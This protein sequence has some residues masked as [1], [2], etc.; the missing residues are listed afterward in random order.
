MKMYRLLLLLLLSLT[1][2]AFAQ[3]LDTEKLDQYFQT[4]A[5]NNKF[6]G[7]VA[8]AKNGEVIYSKAVGMADV[9]QNIPATPQ[10]KYRIGSI[11]KTFTAALVFKAVEENKLT[12]DATLDQ[13]Y[14]KIENASEITL[15]HLLQHRSGIHSFTDDADY[16]SWS[17]KPKTEKEIL[18]IIKKGGSDFKPNT[19]AQYSNTNYVLLSYILEKT[20]DKSFAAILEEKITKPLQLEA[21]YVFGAIDT[22]D[23]ECKS[24]RYLDSWEEQ[25]ETHHSI[26]MGAGAIASTPTDLTTFAHA[27][28]N[29]KLL[30]PE[31]VETMKTIQDGFGMGL[32][33]I[34]FSSKVAYGHNGGIDGFSATFAHFPEDNIAYA[35]TSN[36][37]NYSLNN[38]SIAVLSAVFGTDYDIPTF[39]TYTVSAEELE[40]YLGVY[41][42]DQIP[43]KI[44]VTRDGT[45]L[46][47]QGSGQPAFPLEATAQHTFSCDAVGAKFEFNPKTES[48]TLFQGGRQLEFTKE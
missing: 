45:T 2:P 30:S 16:P 1:Q 3:E 27:L 47:A 42:T 35:L 34:P 21:T 41:A 18:R 8:L 25:S 26:P 24:Y 43:L 46:V 6:M 40:P 36:G 48:M 10:S 44:T 32:F 22:D 5:D 12:L 29:G 7:S 33:Q 11:S 38:I 39:S 20:Y 4:L 19:Q 14:P 17:T 31:H 28:F 15:A 9:D 23:Q 37:S 13:W